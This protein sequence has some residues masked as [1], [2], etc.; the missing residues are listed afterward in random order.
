[1]IGM[2]KQLTI[3][4]S[5]L[6]GLKKKTFPFAAVNRKTFA[7]AA[8]KRKWKKRARDVRKGRSLGGE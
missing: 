8:E 5:E 2:I 6:S 4:S 1:M 7:F 3:S